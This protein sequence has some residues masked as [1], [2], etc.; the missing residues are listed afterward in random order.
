MV[1][2]AEPG[3]LPGLETA[4][5]IELQNVQAGGQTHVRFPVR[6]GAVKDPEH[7]GPLKQN[8]DHGTHKN[9]H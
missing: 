8:R 1:V 5:P 9:G 2:E 4:A 6:V 7:H 3:H